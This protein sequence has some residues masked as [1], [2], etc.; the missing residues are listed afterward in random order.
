M[1]G[2]AVQWGELYRANGSIAEQI[3]V[4]GQEGRDA[5]EHRASSRAEAVNGT[6]CGHGDWRH[7]RQVD[8][9]N[10]FKTKG[11]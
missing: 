7:F 8:I 10:W 5:Q 11:G 9:V 2:H 6:E 4:D 3:R 1:A